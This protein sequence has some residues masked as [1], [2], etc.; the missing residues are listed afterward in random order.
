GV[1]AATVKNQAADGSAA[2]SK[3]DTDVGAG[4][5]ET[6]GGSQSK[7]NSRLSGTEKNNLVVGKLPNGN[8]NSADNI[9]ESTVRKWAGESGADKTAGKSLS[10]LTDKKTS[11][12]TD[13]DALGETALWVGVSGTGRPEDNATK[14][15]RAGDDLKDFAGVVL[16]DSDIKNAEVSI[17]SSG[18]LQGAGGGQ[19]TP[20]GIGAETPTTVQPKINQA[21]INA[22]TNAAA[23]TEGWSEQGATND[24]GWRASADTTRIDAGKVWAG[25]SLTIGNLDGV[26][27]FFR[28]TPTEV[29]LWRYLAGQH[30]LYTSLV[31]HIVGEAES[32]VLTEIN[33]PGG[34]PIYFKDQPKIILSLKDAPLYKADYAGQDQHIR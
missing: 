8:N 9:S 24:S 27:D 6:T 33:G 23:Y 4:T 29:G 12:L 28:A 32:G 26:S 19:V 7:V 25:S 31:Q 22:E 10:V 18:Q 21:Q 15:A 17:T 11:V 34:T 16:G 13:D 5:V 20:D 3:L 2:K 30:R 1:S 14:G